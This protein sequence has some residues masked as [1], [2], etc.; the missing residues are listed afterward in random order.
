MAFEINVQTRRPA[1]N[2][3]IPG[4]LEF[5]IN[6]ATFYPAVSEDGILSWTNDRGLPNPDPVKV[7]G[8]DGESGSPGN[9][10]LPG[11]DGITPHVGSNG[12]WFLGSTDT[13]V[14]ATG[15]AGGQGLPGAPGKD[16]KDGTPATHRWSGTVLEITSASGTS[17]A[18]LKG[19]KGDD[20]APGAKGDK[21]E[22]GEKG[23]PGA[24]GAKGDKGDTG[25]T[26]PEG[27]Q[28]PTGADGAK[29]DKGDTGQRGTGLLAVTSAPASYTTAVGGITPKY[30]MALSTIKTQSGV[31]EVLL[32]D[33]VRSS[34]YHYPIAYLDG[35]YAYFTTRTSIRGATGAAGAAGADG[36]AGVDG[37]SAYAY[38]QDGGYTGT[39][40]EFAEK[41]ASED[42]AAPAD[43]N[44][45]EGEP[46]HVLNRTHWTE[47]DAETEIVHKLDPKYLPEDIFILLD[48]MD[49]VETVIPSINL[50]DGVYEYGRFAAA[51]TEYDKDTPLEGA[52]RNANYLPV[53]GGRTIVAY[54]DKAEWNNNNVGYPYQVVQYDA[55]KN[56][57]VERVEVLPYIATGG[58]STLTLNANTAYIRMCFNRSGTAITT[59]LDEIKFAIYY[60]EDAQ[61]AFV[62]YE[63]T[64]VEKK[65]L[66][67]TS[68]SVLRGKKIVYDGDSICEGRS[69]GTLDNGGGYAKIIA[70]LTGCTAVNQAKGGARLCASSAN[71]SV[72]NN[73][74]NLPKDGD[75]YCFQGGINDFWGNTPIGEC[76]AGYTESV[77]SATIC[78]AM[79]T[80]FRYCLT[81]LLGKA[82]C[83]V[84]T[85][86]VKN[87]ATSANSNG[88][89]FRD[90]RDAMIEVCEKYSIP[91]YDAFTQSGLNGWNTEQSNAYLTANSTGT[92][93]GCHPNADGYK[94]YYVPQLIQLFE[95]IIP[96]DKKPNAPTRAEEVEF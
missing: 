44:A 84:I 25:E 10:G 70:D 15:P 41:L 7:S 48:A 95:R 75:I 51:G 42:G 8:K 2:V 60:L 45:A 24:D 21:G 62:P 37:K 59:P 31:T 46:G 26:G 86:K 54:F 47:Y 82:V 63:P 91:Y 14:P 12:N 55:D 71:H 68:I 76:V 89:T 80:I 3:D 5:G 53:E 33:T 35:S 78:G 74:S 16:G 40:E 29:G 27:P 30:R 43:W 56:I 1:V 69:G 73:L 90:Y 11:E 28:G 4:S 87:T 19:E 50:N 81:N 18:D 57:L 20:G 64:I 65:V 88:D 66:N 17:S 79:E 49:T 6:G 67:A 9:D 61:R 22:K 52:F 85:H 38:A 93:D 72:V 77:D 94:R 58:T 96:V 23:D 36:A 13:G 83:F 39:E 34:Y 32:G 92:G